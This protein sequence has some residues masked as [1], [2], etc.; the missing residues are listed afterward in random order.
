MFEIDSSPETMK[1]FQEWYDGYIQFDKLGKGHI[2][3][4]IDTN[5][6][7]LKKKGREVC[8]KAGMFLEA[9]IG[10]RLNI[11]NTNGWAWTKGKGDWDFVNI[12]SAT[13]ADIKGCRSKDYG[14][15]I[16]IEKSTNNIPSG[17]TKQ[18]REDSSEESGVPRTMDEYLL[19]FDTG[20]F[21]LFVLKTKGLLEYLDLKG[22]KTWGGDNN[23]A[24]GWTISIY[25]LKKDGYIIEEHQL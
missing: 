18:N 4:G 6:S 13:R 19:Y 25:E 9:A 12:S 11:L 7:S 5:D 2:R 10:V 24:E 14:H 15:R 23:A 17:W 22:K 3:K 16:F 1:K 8:W 21:S 20:S